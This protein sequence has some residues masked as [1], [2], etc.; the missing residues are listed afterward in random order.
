MPP[1]MIFK[2]LALVFKIVHSKSDLI[3]NF[4]IKHVDQVLHIKPKEQYILNNIELMKKII[5]NKSK[6]KRKDIY[7]KLTAVMY[8]ASQGTSS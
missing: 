3:Y 6:F 4:N 7:I 2:E 1:I 5:C 8:K